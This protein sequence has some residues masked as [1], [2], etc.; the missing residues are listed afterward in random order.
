M[1]VLTVDGSWSFF[2]ES[3]NDYSEAFWLINQLDK[4]KAAVGE[5]GIWCQ[6]TTNYMYV[7]TA[8]CFT[9]TV[10]AAGTAYELTASQGN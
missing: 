7:N 2:L 9:L 5:T 3:E 6:I 10:T 1:C 8:T 4:T